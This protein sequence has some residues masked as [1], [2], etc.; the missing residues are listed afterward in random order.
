MHPTRAAYLAADPTPPGSPLAGVTVPRSKTGGVCYRTLDERGR[1]L[2]RIETY[3]SEHLETDTLPHEMVHV[4]QNRGFKAFRR[5]HWLDEGLAMLYESKQGR[6][7]RV[8]LWRQLSRNPIP[9]PELLLLKSTP[10][11]R[12]LTFYSEAYVFTRFLRSLGDDDD[13]RRFLDAFGG[14]SFEAA[15]RE[16]YEVEDVAALE[17]LWL[18]S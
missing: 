17:R 18:A 16:V 5:G 6:A 15:V 14:L 11:D 1:P 3:A 8:A 13:W 9:L 2:V 12:V 10:P 4:V 7:N